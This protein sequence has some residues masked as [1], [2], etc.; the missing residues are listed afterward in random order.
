MIIVI[1]KYFR[2]KK[3][4]VSLLV[5]DKLCDEFLRKNKIK[6][7]SKHPDVVVLHSHNQSDNQED[8]DLHDNEEDEIAIVKE[9]TEED[10]IIELLADEAKD[11]KESY[12]EEELDVNNACEKVLADEDEDLNI[13]SSSDSDQ[14]NLGL[15]QSASTSSIQSLS[16]KVEH[17]TNVLLSTIHTILSRYRMVS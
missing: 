5:V 2:D 16:D 14:E 9:K 11:F 17:K 8:D 7:S 10:L 4:E 3:T 12:M 13:S 6:M 1:S 15:A